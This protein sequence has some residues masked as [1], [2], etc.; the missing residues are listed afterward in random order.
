MRSVITGT[1]R[2]TGR[3]V[4]PHLRRSPQCPERIGPVELAATGI[5]HDVPRYYCRAATIRRHRATGRRHDRKLKRPVRAR[6][7]LANPRPKPP[8]RVHAANTR[9]TLDGDRSRCTSAHS[10]VFIFHIALTVRIVAR[11]DCV[12]KGFM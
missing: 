11:E 4:M 5:S 3:R 6:E 7:W 1:R 10:A 2:Q 9:G 12:D 8:R